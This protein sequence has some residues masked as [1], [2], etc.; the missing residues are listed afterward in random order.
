MFD[1]MIERGREVD[2]AHLR[3]AL[4]ASRLSRDPSTKVGAVVV[5]SKG[6]VVS[7]GRN[8]FPQRIE[9]THERWHD[10]EQKLEFVIHA[11]ENALLFAGRA[12]YGGTVYITHPPCK[13]CALLLIQ[14]GI[15]R[16]VAIDPPEDLKARWGIH[17][18]QEVLGEAGVAVK[19]YT[20]EE[21]RMARGSHCVV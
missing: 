8:G 20:L 1:K 14:A 11:E 19:L 5:D 12:A 9:D 4:E 13:H 10:R 6:V 18:A 7:T 17:R 3:M 21:T 2:I 15:E 16:V